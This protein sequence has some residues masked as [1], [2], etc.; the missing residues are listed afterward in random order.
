MAASV[1]YAY[2][3]SGTV[4][5]TSAQAA[6]ANMTNANVVFAD[7]DTTATVTH[8]MALSTAQLANQWPL[9]VINQVLGGT[10]SP[11]LLVTKAANSIVLTKQSTASGSG[12]TV[13]VTVLRPHSIIT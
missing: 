12:G 10:P 3:V 2:P 13:D 11:L 4:A 5:P 6:A 1:N 9:V 7:A 8:S